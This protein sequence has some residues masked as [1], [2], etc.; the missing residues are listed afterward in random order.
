MTLQHSIQKGVSDFSF[1]IGTCLKYGGAGGLLVMA[2]VGTVAI[3]LVL[4]AAAEKH[5]NSFLTGF[6]L[7]S[8][9]SRGNLDP[10]P[11]LI[12]SPITSAVAVVLSVALGVPG[13]GL[14]ILAGWTL[15]GTLLAVGMGLEAF[16]KS[17]NPEPSSE[18]DYNSCLCFN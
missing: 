3:D 9:F 8:M 12:A 13:V 2:V 11:L 18:S 17:I 7:G 10:V 6:V 16:A 15:A 14:A 4:L 1:I 5:H